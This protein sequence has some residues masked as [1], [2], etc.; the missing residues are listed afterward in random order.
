MS[1]SRYWIDASS[2]VSSSRLSWLFV[3]LSS[4]FTVKWLPMEKSRLVTQQW[5]LLVLS[6]L[7]CSTHFP[8]DL[9]YESS[10]SLNMQVVWVVASMDETFASV[11]QFLFC[12]K[13]QS[14]KSAFSQIAFLWWPWVCLCLDRFVLSTSRRFNLSSKLR[15]SLPVVS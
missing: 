2:R 10:F 3:A 14:S 1:K 11:G 6:F 7:T 5:P 13:N 8:V 4:Y 15:P 9:R 12:R